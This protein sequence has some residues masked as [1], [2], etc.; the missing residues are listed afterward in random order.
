MNVAY[1]LEHILSSLKGPTADGHAVAY[2]E[3]VEEWLAVVLAMIA[4]FID[5]YGMITYRTYLSFM[6]GNTTQAGY[7]IGEGK[8][9]PAL[10][11]VLVAIVFFVGGSFA[12]SLLADSPA[13]RIRRLIFGVTAIALCLIIGSTRVGIF[14][15]YVNIA[16]ISFTMGAMNTALSQDGTR[17]RM[18]SQLVSLTFVTGMLSKIGM[19][20]ALAV[21]RS[22]GGHSQE[23]WHTHVRRAL[24]LATVWGGFLSG[25]LLSGAATPRVGAW[26]LL[27][28]MLI[29]LALAAFDRSSSAQAHPGEW[30]IASKR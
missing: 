1:N 14:S 19:Q 30:N 15:D 7:Q 11:S 9:G 24:L 26:A 10:Y 20:L 27:F 3:E 6:S 5:A 13:R 4:G 18:G 25:A 29:L 22:P 28:P 21:R 23:A 2:E 8:F 17:Y 16:I 12:G